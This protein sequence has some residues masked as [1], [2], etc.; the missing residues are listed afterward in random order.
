MSNNEC[1]QKNSGCFNPGFKRICEEGLGGFYGR[2]AYCV[3][4]YSVPVQS[5][6]ISLQLDCKAE[7]YCS[8]TLTNRDC[9][10]TTSSAL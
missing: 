5:L 10:Y 7:K 2:V 6:P 9:P 4:W 8:V 3:F 1:L